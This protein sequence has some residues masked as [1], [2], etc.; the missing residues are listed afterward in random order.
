MA[1]AARLPFGLNIF[2]SQKRIRRCLKCDI[3][4]SK[5]GQKKYRRC[6]HLPFL[7]TWLLF[8]CIYSP[9]Y[10][11]SYAGLL[12]LCFTHL[13]RYILFSLTCHI[14]CACCPN[15]RDVTVRR[16]TVD[17]S[18]LLLTMHLR[19]CELVNRPINCVV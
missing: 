1:R 15:P 4:L 10:S 13:T 8:N 6:M 7:E 12:I 14:I 5:R 11:S 3:T 9:S 2:Y 17:G 16:L 18:L 19:N